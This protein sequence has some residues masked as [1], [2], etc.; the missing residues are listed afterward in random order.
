MSPS[1]PSPAAPLL[2]ETVDLA[3]RGTAVLDGGLV[4]DAQV[5][6]DGEEIVWTGP[7]THAPELAA[8]T[9]IEHPGLILPG[10]VDLHCH[11][12]GG[13]SFPD[14]SGPEQMLIA[15]HEHR[16]HGTTSLVASLVTASAQTLRER[17]RDLTQLAEAG[18]IAAI[19]LEGP[20]VSV[21]RRGAQN[22][23]HIIE[24]DPALVRELSDL[25][26][27]HLATVTLAPESPG[28][29]AAI[30]VLAEVGAIPSLG[31]T[32]AGS[33]RMTAAVEHAG[34]ALRRHR[35]RS[36]RPTATHLFN[37]MRPIH[38]R[39]PGPALAALAA[40][41]RAEL[42]VELIADGVHLA[43]ETVAHVFA[44]AAEDSVALITDAMAAA[45]M[46]DGQ[47]ELGGQQV[48]VQGPTAT[49]TGSGSGGGSIAGG[50]AHLLDVL[51]FAVQEA[52]VDLVTAV[53]AAS[54][55]PAAVLGMQDRIGALAVGRR[56]DVLLVDAQLR[57]ITVLRAGSPVED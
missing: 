16:R 6:I 41:S 1:P 27:G 53:R 23:A 29:D 20:F 52:G 17:V 47:Y 55:T 25:A 46:P 40:A 48:T 7:A 8:A 33:G 34:R 42:V 21:A 31:H 11:G 37:G 56:A 10:L 13:A 18:E 43:A 50:T 32:D 26:Q 35:G 9:R 19:H 38:H 4:P 44:V 57:P 39:D 15:V 49:L 45:G 51:R 3:L 36:A 2:P 28:A 22:P 12:G 24:A 30:D 14:S 5:L 54:S